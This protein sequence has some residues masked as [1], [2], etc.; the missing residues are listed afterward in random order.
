M[1]EISERKHSEPAALWKAMSGEIFWARRMCGK[2][3][4]YVRRSKVPRA[5]KQWAYRA[6]VE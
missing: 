5:I 1:W 6:A 3:A 4:E 2:C